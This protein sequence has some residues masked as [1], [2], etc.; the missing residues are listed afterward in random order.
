MTARRATLVSVTAASAQL[1]VSLSTVW[2]LIRKGELPTVRV[3]GRRLVRAASL[4]LRV[5]KKERKTAEPF[6]RDNPIWA[7]VGAYK[8]AGGR[9]A[10]DKHAILTR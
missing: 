2:R 1:G 10:E 9:G 8:S 3:G 5:E 4:R 6:T 7:L